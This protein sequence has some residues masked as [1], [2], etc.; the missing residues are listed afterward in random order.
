MLVED[1]FTVEFLFLHAVAFEFVQREVDAV[2]L[3]VFTNVSEDVGQLHE[4]TPGFGVLFGHGVVVAVD[5][6]AHQSDH[7]S[8]PVA[9]NVEFV[10]G[11]ISVV[12]EVVLH[13]GNQVVKHVPWNRIALDRVLEREE[14]RVGGVNVSVA[15]GQFFAEEEQLRDLVQVS[16][17]VE[18]CSSVLEGFQLVS[19]RRR[20]GVQ[21][22]LAP[23][24]S[25]RPI[26]VCD[27]VR[28]SAKGVDG[29]HGE[30]LFLWQ[31]L[32]RV[33]EITRF[34]HG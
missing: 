21:L 12:V 1:N 15:R 5:F 16:F 9:V 8:D 31:I 20:F 28:T 3:D 32:E 27:V 6:N 23:G 7:G 4:N 19:I 30:A 13:A 24:E 25:V 14:N 17:L 33:V 34:S 26:A 10:K 11:S 2:S 29:A 22:S 18:D